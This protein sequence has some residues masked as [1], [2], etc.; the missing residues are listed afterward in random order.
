MLVTLYL[1]KAELE[2]I[3]TVAAPTGT[4]VFVYRDAWT[5]ATELGISLSE[6]APEDFF[7]IL[8][9]YINSALKRAFKDWL[10]IDMYPLVKRAKR[11]ANRL[12]SHEVDV[13]VMNIRAACKVLEVPARLYL[14][15]HDEYETPHIEVF[16]S[17]VIAAVAERD[18][19]EG[20]VFNTTTRGE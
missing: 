15:E 5:R 11:P 14:E 19:M 8:N 2:R 6:K 9:K 18:I 1:N 16:I 17:T 7:E 12:R 10:Q 13:T 3:I 20:T 4:L